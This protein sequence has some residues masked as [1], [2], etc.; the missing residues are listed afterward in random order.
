MIYNRSNFGLPIN[1]WLTKQ[2]AFIGLILSSLVINLLG[3]IFPIAVLQFYDRIIPQKSYGTLTV[4]IGV[5]ILA[6]IGETILKILR[7]YVSAWSSAR[8]TY[9]MG[10]K[11]FRHLLYADLSQ[12]RL[13]SPGIYLDKF[14]S[15]ESIREYYCGQNLT[16]LVDLPFI[17]VYLA[18]MFFISP[19]LSVIPLL[20]II[21]MVYTGVWSGIETFKQMESKSNMS[22]VKSKFLIEMI[23][24]IHTIKALGMEEQFL[25]RYERLHQRE[26]MSNYEFIQKTSENTRNSSFYSQLAV[27]L[28]GFIGG[29]LVIYH[30]LSVGGLAASILITG[31]LMLPV[32]KLITYLEKKQQLNIAK[33]DLQFILKYQPE[34]A[35]G[36]LRLDTL[37]GDIKLSNVSFKYPSSEIY[38]F[39]DINLHVLP[40]QNIVLHGGLFSGKSTLLRLISSLYKPVEG[41]IEVD[42]HNLKDLDLDSYRRKVA[43][44]SESGELFSGTIMENLTL[45]EVDKYANEAKELAKVLGFHDIV[46]SMPQSYD[47]MV[48]TGTVDLLSKGHKQLILIIRTL[49]NDPQLILFDEANLSLDIDSDV[50]LR[51]YLVSKKG[52]CT[53]ILVTHRPSLIE[54]GDRHF[55]LEHGKLTEFKWQ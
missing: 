38:I 54:T 17:A 15:A 18:L 4:L 3:L 50:R 51:K 45:F 9:N 13:V 55:R 30:V 1:L 2:D 8:F 41:I 31:R 12:I 32:T 16:L 11:L 35:D 34:Y 33:D 44:M 23:S 49:L 22:E 47:T 24:G 6:L 28:T 21:V 43:Y 53:M 25:R 36:L 52:T 27:I 20:V 37:D 48:G 40:K 10:A 7:G 39:K 26:I 19:Y 14:N 42:G 46:E 29:V 5:I